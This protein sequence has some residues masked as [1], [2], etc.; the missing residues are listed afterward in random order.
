MLRILSITGSDVHAFD[1]RWIVIHHCRSAWHTH[2]ALIYLSLTGLI[3]RTVVVL[4]PI[5]SLF[6]L[7][8]SSGNLCFFLQGHALLR[9]QVDNSCIWQT[10]VRV[11]HVLTRMEIIAISCR[12]L[13]A[14]VD[15][16]DSGPLLLVHGTGGQDVVYLGIFDELL[17]ALSHVRHFQDLGR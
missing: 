7:F 3:C 10:A 4:G 16:T 12:L 1:T 8:L 5:R 9:R 14:C 2:H 6:Q 13:M 15:A 17:H 11:A